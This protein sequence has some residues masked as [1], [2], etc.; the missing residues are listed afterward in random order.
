MLFAEVENEKSKKT[1]FIHNTNYTAE[2]P[3][4]YTYRQRFAFLARKLSG[5]ARRAVYRRAFHRDHRHLRYGACYGK[6]RRNLECIR[7]GCNIAFNSD[8][9]AWHNYLYD[10]RNADV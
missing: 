2:F 7:A 4:R 1:L 6:H 8:R 5:R 9:R 3:R 10:R